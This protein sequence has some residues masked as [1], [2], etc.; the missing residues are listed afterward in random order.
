MDNR[1]DQ[2]YL[3]VPF[4]KAKGGGYYKVDFGIG[5]ESRTDQTLFPKKR[6]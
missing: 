6:V 5:T 3:N 1:S 2:G 4:K